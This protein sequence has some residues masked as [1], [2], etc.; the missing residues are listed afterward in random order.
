MR[1]NKVGAAADIDAG[2]GFGSVPPAEGLGVTA[3]CGGRSKAHREQG[4]AGRIV[5]ILARFTEGGMG[6]IR[7]V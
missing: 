7:A 5:S 4:V 2:A 1:E 3:L 6:F